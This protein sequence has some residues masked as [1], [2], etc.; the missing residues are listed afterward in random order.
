[1][2]RGKFPRPGRGK[3]MIRFLWSNLKG[4]RFL[5]IFIFAAT[6]FEVLA[7][8]YGIVVIKDIFN[9]VVPPQSPAKGVS[10]PSKEPSAPFNLVLNMYSLAPHS[11]QT[12]VTFLIIVLVVLGLLD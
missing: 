5:V 6:I 3:I 9:V 8:S 11:S 7:S 4:Y 12:I 10:P 2:R 1:M